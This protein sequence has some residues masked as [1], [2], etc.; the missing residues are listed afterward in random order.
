MGVF[1]NARPEKGKLIFEG[2]TSR[3]LPWSKKTT[4]RCFLTFICLGVRLG[5][6]VALQVGP[7][8]LPHLRVEPPE[9]PAGERDT[10][11]EVTR[12]RRAR[13]ARGGFS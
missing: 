3:P 5:T 7:Q 1:G 6:C 12:A 10:R 13:E 8:R 11:T 4:T 9:E 2:K